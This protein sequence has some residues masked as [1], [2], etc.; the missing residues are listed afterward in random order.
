MLVHKA[1]TQWS[2][3]QRE[4]TLS[5]KILGFKT[6]NRF[7]KGE[8]IGETEALLPRRDLLKTGLLGAE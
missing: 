6:P 8:S 7:L 1:S 3:G 2:A 4:G 5:G